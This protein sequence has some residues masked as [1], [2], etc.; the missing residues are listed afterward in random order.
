M[1]ML[2]KIKTLTKDFKLDV[3]NLKKLILT[4]KAGAEEISYLKMNYLVK[5]LQAIFKRKRIW[6][7]KN[8][9]RAS[10]RSY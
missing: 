2:K 10:P 9:Q 6:K 4:K 8:A 5:L 3:K 1:E 7:R